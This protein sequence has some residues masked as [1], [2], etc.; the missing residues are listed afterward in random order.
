MLF[1]LVLFCCFLCVFLIREHFVL[2]KF[3]FCHKFG[4]YC[5]CCAL[6]RSCRKH[7][8][9]RRFKLIHFFVLFVLVVEMHHS[10]LF[11]RSL[12]H[13][14]VLVLFPFI[15]SCTLAVVTN[16]VQL[17]SIQFDA[18]LSLHSSNWSLLF[19]SLSFPF[20]CCI[21]PLVLFSLFLFFLMFI[22]SLPDLILSLFPSTKTLFLCS[23][24]F[25]SQSHLNC[26]FTALTFLSFEQMFTLFASLN[27]S[28][29][30]IW[31]LV[32]LCFCFV[33]LSWDPVDLTD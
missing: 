2:P 6:N 7:S 32:W 28:T 22:L 10:I 11:F 21:F 30:S 18:I 15:F 33:H 12:L 23:F 1:N 25:L 5:F 24:L 13:F 16:P 31:S 3:V 4:L 20:L 17:S 14:C 8:K 9:F 29:F 27:K 19:L 26:L